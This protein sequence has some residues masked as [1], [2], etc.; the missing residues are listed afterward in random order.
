MAQRTIMK[1]EV[2]VTACEVSNKSPAE[3]FSEAIPVVTASY[4][5]YG[6]WKYEDS[7]K[8][9]WDVV[10][11]CEDILR[12]HDVVILEPQGELL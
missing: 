1:E 2:F 8:I 9:P 11:F 6:K 4:E 7:S 10:T 5:A 12:C 3:V